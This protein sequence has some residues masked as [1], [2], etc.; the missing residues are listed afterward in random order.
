VVFG[1]F[2]VLTACNA[3][4]EE[5]AIQLYN[6]QCASCHQ[7]PK[8]DE[9]PK[10]LWQENILPRMA[11]RMG[12][13]SVDFNPRAGFSFSEQAA[14]I[15]SG[16]YTVRPTISDDDW[17]LLHDYIISMA[18]DSLASLTTKKPKPLQKFKAR[19]I[20]I[21][22]MLSSR[23]TFLDYDE[24]SSN[25]LL[26]NMSGNL[27]AYD[28]VT[29]TTVVKHL[30]SNPIVDFHQTDSVAFTTLIGKLSPTQLNS[31]SIIRTQKNKGLGIASNLHRPV[32]TV[33]EDLNADGKKEL[34]VAE[35][36]H[37][38]GQLSLVRLDANGNYQKSALLA[39]PGMLRTL[40]KDM[41]ADGKTDLVV[42]SSQ[43]DEGIWIL[44]Q[45]GNLKFNP[46]KVLRFS[47]VF[48]TSWFELVDYDGDGDQDI[49]TVHGD[50]ADNSYVPK[51]YHGVRIH[52]NNGQNSFKEVYFYPMYGATRILAK[53]FDADND[54]DIAA[55][56]AFP[57]Y[58]NHPLN[59]FVY[60]ENNGGNTPDFTA[61][62]HEKA[63]HGRWFLIDS[64]D[65]DQDGDEDIIVS[66]FSFGFTPTS[67]EMDAKW[68]E[69]Q[70]DLLVLENQTSQ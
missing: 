67:K 6:T 27:L 32:H 24:R 5:K 55:V 59:S 62:T 60:L 56:A 68:K 39:Q 1:L 53:D 49:I 70:I 34:V 44:F 9:L 25:L 66:A 63:D 64:G 30:F 17:A 37:L 23:Y 65:I 69:K 22:R 36:G 42:A 2:L 14:I 21:D 31:G 12:V 19:T 13:R 54:I 40:A 20:D 8:I 51:P 11:A 26:G 18:P 46:K 38:T 35:F 43:G 58:A 16:I 3:S 48:G 7:A 47:P 45:E 29:D 61:F 57:N 28:F 33:V 4:K 50:N 10:H 15:E 52:L 41:N